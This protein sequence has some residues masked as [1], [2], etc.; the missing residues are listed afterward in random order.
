MNPIEHRQNFRLQVIS[1]CAE[2]GFPSC[3]SE[4]SQHHPHGQTAI[5]APPADSRNV[6]K[7]QDARRF[8]QALKAKLRMMMLPDF[9][10]DR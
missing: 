9:K 3:H 2:H 10:R 5:N 8:E 1:G 4:Q 6:I 7:N